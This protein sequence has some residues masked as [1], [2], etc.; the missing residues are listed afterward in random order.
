MKIA[1]INI[2]AVFQDISPGPVSCQPRFDVPGYIHPHTVNHHSHS[3][4]F[5]WEQGM[6]LVL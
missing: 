5:V 2:F 3:H 4:I 1:K 6:V